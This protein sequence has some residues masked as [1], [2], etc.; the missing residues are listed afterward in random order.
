MIFDGYDGFDISSPDFS[1]QDLFHLETGG[2]DVSFGASLPDLQNAATLSDMANVYSETEYGQ[3]LHDLADSLSGANMPGMEIIKDG[4]ADASAFYGIDPVNVFYEAGQ[5]GLQFSG[6][7]NLPYDNWIGGDPD[8][9]NNYCAQYGQEFSQCVIG[10]EMGHNMVDLLE[11]EGSIPRI[12]NEALSDWMAGIYAGSRGLDPNG[13]AQFLSD[14]PAEGCFS[15]HG[16][17]LYPGGMERK[18]LFMEG[19]AMANNYAFRDFQSII[20]DPG[21]NL[22]AQAWEIAHRYC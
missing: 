11:L 16:E 1:D 10:H 15:E 9:L 19:Y 14:Q 5:P 22:K 20:N 8:M 6:Y 17:Q 2:D 21:F 7:T 3:T 12:A 13:F 4:V 18:D